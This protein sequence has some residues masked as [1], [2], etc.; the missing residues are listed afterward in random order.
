MSIIRINELPEGSGNLTNDDVFI[1]M[2]NPSSGGITKKISLSELK[3]IINDRLVNGEYQ[4]VLGSDG[5]TSFPVIEGTK[6][7]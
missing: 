6:T 2:D 7:L 5:M 3:S 1:F 4:V